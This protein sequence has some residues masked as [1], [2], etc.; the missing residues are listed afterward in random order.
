M[1]IPLVT[2]F[3]VRALVV[4]SNVLVIHM[5]VIADIGGQLDEVSGNVAVSRLVADLKSDDVDVRRNAAER[6]SQHGGDLCAVSV[7]LVEAC[8]DEDEEVREWVVTALEELKQPAESDLQDLADLLANDSDDVGYWAATLIGRLGK[9]AL[10][11]VPALVAA[12]ADTQGLL[13]QQRAAWALGKIGRKAVDAL[14]ALEKA[15]A[16]Q[17]A[18]LSRLA[19]GAIEGIRG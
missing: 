18:R 9:A 16:S 17:N 14:P 5:A 10:P 15:A 11:A 8:A 4:T 6:I 2:P 12:L 13:T 1:R 19:T 7:E 3:G